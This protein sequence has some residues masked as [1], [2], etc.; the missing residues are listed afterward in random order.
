MTLRE[1]EW[2]ICTAIEKASEGCGRYEKGTQETKRNE[3]S[4][5]VHRV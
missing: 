1:S 3:V 4:L 5:Q 2:V